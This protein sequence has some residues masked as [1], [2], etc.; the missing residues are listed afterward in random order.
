[1]TSP[2]RCHRSRRLRGHAI[3]K[4]II[5]MLLL[6]SFFFTFSNLKQFTWGQRCQRRREYRRKNE[7]F[8]EPILACSYGAQVEFLK[9]VS[10][11]L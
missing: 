1:M 3:F 9:K 6:L 2:T 11:I 8:R 4:N 5:S 10:K 7:K